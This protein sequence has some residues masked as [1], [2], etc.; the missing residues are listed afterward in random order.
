MIVDVCFQSASAISELPVQRQGRCLTQS[1]RI[2]AAAGSILTLRPHHP[3]IH[4]VAIC[5]ACVRR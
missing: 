1:R 4:N 3:D 2:P 5:Y